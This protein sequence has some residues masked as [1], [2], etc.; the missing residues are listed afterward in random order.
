MGN[1]TLESLTLASLLCFSW[2]CPCVFHWH[3]IPF[4]QVT[5]DGI[6]IPCPS[7][8]GSSHWDLAQEWYAF[9]R[10]LGDSYSEAQIRISY[11]LYTRDTSKTLG[12]FHSVVKVEA[13]QVRVLRKGI[14][15]FSCNQI[16]GLLT[17]CPVASDGN[18]SL[19]ENCRMGCSLRQED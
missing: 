18:L 2:L 1:R 14:L 6:F 4:S 8:T 13:S 5:L 16:H 15:Y 7:V 3:P 19:I 11:L 10:S 9:C 12:P 17:I